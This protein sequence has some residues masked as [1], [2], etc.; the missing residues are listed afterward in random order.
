MDELYAAC[1]TEYEFSLDLKDPAAMPAVAAA[2]E[3]AGGGAFERLWIC[4]HDLDVLAEW[5]SMWPT[6]RLVHS[7]F[8][9]HMDGGPERHAARLTELGIDA[10]NL[11]HTEWT[12]GFIALYHRFDRLAFA[13]DVQHTWTLR[14]SVRRGV[15]AVYCD[16]PRLLVTVLGAKR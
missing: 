13:W 2:A 12:G 3:Q 8:I 16:H 5:R 11:H 15:D 4:H 10:V 7:T 6:I 9:G 1:G 14:W